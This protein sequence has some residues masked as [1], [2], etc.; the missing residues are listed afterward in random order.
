MHGGRWNHPLTAC[1]YTSGSRALALLEYTVNV[2]IAYIPRTL[3]I[4]TLDV[5]EDAT[6]LLTVAKLPHDWQL[7]PSPASTKD[8]GT[9]LL[10]KA[11]HSVICVPSVI[12]PDEFNYLINPYHPGIAKVKI[13]SVR[14][15]SYDLRIK[16]L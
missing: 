13:V 7:V 6:V 15:L 9:A 14:D 8:L 3:S 1:V 4:V 11:D 10:Q 5:P 16:S 12:L 2:N